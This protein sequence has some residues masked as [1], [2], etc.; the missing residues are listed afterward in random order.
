MAIT[1]SGILGLIAA[2][3]AVYIVYRIVKRKMKGGIKSYANL[4]YPKEETEE[5]RRSRE[6][7]NGSEGDIEGVEGGRT[8]SPSSRRSFKFTK[9]TTPTSDGRQSDVET[10]S[11]SA[12]RIDD[13]ERDKSPKRKFRFSS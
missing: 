4:E 12:E 3:I 6:R 11:K 1:A 7:I 5:E 8:R 2:G 13:S 9:S 10:T